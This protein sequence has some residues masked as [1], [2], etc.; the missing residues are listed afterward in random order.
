MF[1]CRAAGW[2]W[3]FSRAGPEMAYSWRTPWQPE[4]KPSEKTQRARAICIERAEALLEAAAKEMSASR[5]AQLE[6]LAPGYRSAAE[7]FSGPRAWK[8]VGSLSSCQ[9]FR[10]R[11]A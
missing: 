8:S 4:P 3:G 11:P 10:R 6:L 5:R 7:G 2:L 9:D 1:I